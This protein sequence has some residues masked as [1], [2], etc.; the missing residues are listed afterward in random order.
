MQPDLD[1][2]KGVQEQG[3]CHPS[4]GA[5]HQVLPSHW[6]ILELMSYIEQFT[7]RSIVLQNI[8]NNK[9]VIEKKWEKVKNSTKKPEE[10]N[11]ALLNL[12][13]SACSTEVV[14]YLSLLLLSLLKRC[15]YLTCGPLIICL[16]LCV[17]SALIQ[18]IFFNTF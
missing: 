9:W 1:E 2:V 7:M 11:E 15:F 8:F 18:E 17:M 10:R 12:M 14:I 13:S 3:G 6:Q 5:C 4:H 16:F